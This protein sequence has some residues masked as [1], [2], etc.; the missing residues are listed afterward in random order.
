MLPDLLIGLAIAA[1]CGA[2]AARGIYNRRHGRHSCSCGG[3]CDS[4]G[5]SGACHRGQERTPHA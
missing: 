2:I 5:C 4:C 1:V 3:S